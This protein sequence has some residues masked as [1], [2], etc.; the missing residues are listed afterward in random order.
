M[1]KRE[2]DERMRKE[3]AIAIS[4]SLFWTIKKAVSGVQVQGCIPKRQ[5]LPLQPENILA[6]S[7][8]FSNVAGC[9]VGISCR[10]H[11]C[12]TQ[13]HQCAGCKRLDLSQHLGKCLRGILPSQP[14]DAFGIGQQDRAPSHHHRRTHSSVPA[15]TNRPLSHSK[16]ICCAVTEL[17]A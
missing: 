7:G 16:S 14:H 10:V 2:G 8:F 9:L 6:K 11:L 1:Q 12:L 4:F 15:K 17:Q 3:P 5:F 13:P